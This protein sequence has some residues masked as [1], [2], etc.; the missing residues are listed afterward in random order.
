MARYC[1][2]KNSDNIADNVIIWNGTDP[3]TPP[4][5]HTL[6]QS[7]VGQIE[8]KYESGK[9]YYYSNFAI[10]KNITGATQANPV[11]I[12]SASHGFSNDDSIKIYNIIGMIELND[13]EY[14]VG[15]K[16]DNTFELSGIDGTGYTAYVS[17][18][19][20]VKAGWVERT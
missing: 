15:N 14:V 11:V 20:A 4:V 7:N 18:G 9:F 8:D 12:A 19:I 16:T 10:K 13:N 17:G 1:V 2:V 6:V 3:Y 5:N